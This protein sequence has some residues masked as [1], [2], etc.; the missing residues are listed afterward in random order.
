MINLT[1]LC[2][3]LLL[4]MTGGLSSTYYRFDPLI[5]DYSTII[6]AFKTYVFSKYVGF[7][8]E[9]M[10]MEPLFYQSVRYQITFS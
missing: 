5:S 1:L 7:A 8:I 3:I 2:L 10:L 6:N 4:F 9:N